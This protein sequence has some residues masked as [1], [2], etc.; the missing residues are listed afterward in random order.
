MRVVASD[1]LILVVPETAPMR[2]IAITVLALS[3]CATR[4]RIQVYVDPR[5]RR[6]VAASLYLAWRAL[7][8]SGTFAPDS[9]AE[10]TLCRETQPGAIAMANHSP[11]GQLRLIKCIQEPSELIDML[12]WTGSEIVDDDLI[13]NDTRL[14]SFANRQAGATGIIVGTGPSLLSVDPN[15]LSQFPTIG[16]NKLF[17]LDRHYHFRP[18]F[19]MV[20]DRLILEDHAAELARYAPTERLYPFDHHGL[21][22][23]LCFPLWRSYEPFPQFSMDFGN[24]AYSGWSVTFVMLQFAYFL[25]WKR[26]L[27]V[28]IDGYRHPPL[29]R[30]SGDV[31]KSEGPDSDHFDPEYYGSGRRFHRSRPELV[32]AAFRHAASILTRAGIQVLN[33]SKGTLVQ[34]FP[35]QTLES[36]L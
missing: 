17:L 13:A 14:R 28:G 18:N 35:T 5:I 4:P 8:R 2:L 34:A 15:L 9:V 6:H 30:Y 31:G 21:A 19:L 11:L 16:C 24:G 36:A 12:R 3:R 32:E 29:A 26:I 7:E 20:E 33:C 1:S 22:N 10:E 27:M 25:G 23:A